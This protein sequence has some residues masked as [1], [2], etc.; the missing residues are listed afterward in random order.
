MIKI[1][2]ENTTDMNNPLLSKYCCRENIC[3]FEEAKL[4]KFSEKYTISTETYKNSSFNQMVNKQQLFIQVFNVTYKERR[5]IALE[6]CHNF[7]SVWP[8]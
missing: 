8:S 1:G 4:F 7:L 3:Q 6:S 5:T 2:I